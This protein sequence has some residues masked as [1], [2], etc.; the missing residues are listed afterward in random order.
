MLG[1]IVVNNAILLV[2]HSNLLYQERGMALKEAILEAGRRRLRPILMTALTTILALLPLALGL[3]EGAETQAPM[4][5]T[6]LGGLL[7]S[8]LITL[9]FVPVV[10]FL[11]KTRLGKRQEPVAGEGERLEGLEVKAIP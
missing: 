3:G 5:R 11:F 6:V 2:D 10:Y 7:S 8:T 4:A 9:V 1:G